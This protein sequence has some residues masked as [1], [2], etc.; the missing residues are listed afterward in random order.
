MAGIKS[1]WGNWNYKEKILIGI[2]FV[3]YCA[4]L[5]RFRSHPG[6]FGDFVKA[7]ELI[8]NQKNP[9]SQLMYVNSPV[10]AVIFY[11]LSRILPI[12]LIPTFI[13]ILNLIGIMFF[14]KVVLKNANRANLLWIFVVL[15]LFNST[16]ALLANVQVTGLLLG[17]IAASLTLT[18]NSAPAYKVVFPLWLAM[19]I[20]PQ[21]AVPFVLVFLFDSKIHKARILLLGIYYFAAHLV[22]S[23]KFGSS[24]DQLWIKKIVSYSSNSMKEGYEISYWKGLA[25]LLGEEKYIQIF[26]QGVVMITLCFV[27]YFALKSQTNWAILLAILFPIQNSYLHLYDLVPAS[28]LIASLYLR[29]N[30]T[31]LLFGLLILMQIYPLNFYTQ[32]SILLFCL[33]LNI[34]Q[35]EMMSKRLI[36]SL[37]MF[38]HSIFVLILLDNYSEEMQI[39]LSLTIP[40][41]I[42][43]LV[44]RQK[45]GKLIA[46]NSASSA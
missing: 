23:F 37:L 38:S 24:I 7:G 5:Y 41:I 31:S 21:L 34:S 6:D 29:K 19:E 25:I 9:Y 40:L 11:L 35:K 18:R 27:V 13:Q 3:G 33:L 2:V 42:V 22:V 36:S 46:F 20:K 26:S 16:R 14:F 43:L 1:I 45:L 10:S 15:L 4:L 32:L 28:I 30:S 39:I 44:N 12:L 17:L 8:W